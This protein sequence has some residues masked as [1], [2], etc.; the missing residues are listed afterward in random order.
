ML[1]EQTNLEFQEAAASLKQEL[2]KLGITLS[3]PHVLLRP[4]I[5]LDGNQ[6]CALYG[7]NLHDGVA[8]F[9]DSPCEAMADFDRA[10]NTRL[11]TPTATF[12]SPEEQADSMN[13]WEV[14]RDAVADGQLEIE[15]G[16]MTLQAHGYACAKTADGRQIAV[17]TRGGW[18]LLPDIIVRQMNSMLTKR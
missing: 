8:G 16:G 13:G 3:L 6:W 14:L 1:S 10:W 12:K 7:E 2:Y 4:Q 5:S 17:A 9:G 18:M 11:T 15:E